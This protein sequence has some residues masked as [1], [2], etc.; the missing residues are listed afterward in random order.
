MS[1]ISRLQE[2][3]T[4]YNN[5]KISLRKDLSRLDRLLN[6]TDPESPLYAKYM[7]EKEKIIVQLYSTENRYDEAI[8]K[9]TQA[10]K[11][12]EE[13]NK[14]SKGF[15]DPGQSRLKK[16]LTNFVEKRIDSV[17]DKWSKIRN[18]YAY[19]FTYSGVK[20][21]TYL[22][23]AVGKFLINAALT[24][25]VDQKKFL[26]FSYGG[27]RVGRFKFSNNNLLRKYSSDYQ[28]LGNNFYLMGTGFYNRDISKNKLDAGDV[29]AYMKSQ[30][31][32]SEEILKQLKELSEYGF[33]VSSIYMNLLDKSHKE[34]NIL[35]S[36]GNA[37][38]Y[39]DVNVQNQA[40]LINEENKENL[41][42]VLLDFYDYI[43]DSRKPKKKAASIFSII[44]SI[45]KGAW[46]L[47]K[48]LGLAVA[49][50]ALNPLGLGALIVAACAAAFIFWGDSITNAIK[51]N[52][53]DFWKWLTNSNENLFEMKGLDESKY[54]ILPM[55]DSWKIPSAEDF[56]KQMSDD[57]IPELDAYG[58]EINSDIEKAIAEASIHTGLEPKDI[59]AI[60]QTESD[61][62]PEAEGPQ[63]KY[64]KAQGAMQLL[65][66]T[67]N[68]M[69]GTNIKDP[70]E[71][72]I[73]G[74]TYYA[75]LKNKYEGDETKAL[76]AYNWGLGNVDEAIV[77]YGDEDWINYAP[78]E[79]KDYIKKNFIYRQA[80]IDRNAMTKALSETVDI[81]NPSNLTVQNNIS[82][83]IEPNALSPEAMKNNKIM[84]EESISSPE[85]VQQSLN[86]Y[87]NN[88]SIE[89]D[90]SEP[91]SIPDHL[92]GGGLAFL[93][94][95]ARF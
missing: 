77:K 38:D 60:I 16:D 72:I 27:R 7:A 23:K 47:V 28:A 11:N 29:V 62:D 61:F 83:K 12:L 73:A 66:S 54:G 57:S 51:L 95:G 39:D 55:L 22:G 45:A 70:R 9:L 48:W 56:E 40:I 84:L 26:G 10:V 44:S 46:S 85:S 25:K 19:R 76:A 21:A 37:L 92:N 36:S 50:L 89:D 33:V 30:G 20:G 65:P 67:F 81:S 68:E 24:K 94:S 80:I 69:G 52:I 64:G 5:R 18:S 91:I 93:N 6:N 34:G 59:V 87:K 63:T 58:R 42:D 13:K 14:G 90:S 74:S 79:T 32:T 35:Q 17:M 3:K 4:I 75:Y 31:A 71:N 2:N 78:K 43:L 88:Y 82:P 41:K 49:G 15:F 53:N 86:N 1:D 8:N